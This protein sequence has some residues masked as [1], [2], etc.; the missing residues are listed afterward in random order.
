MSR[1]FAIASAFALVTALASNPAQ[2]AQR[3]FVASNGSDANTATGCGLAQPCRSFTAA[4]TVVDSGG[5]VLAL[6]AAGYGQV[7]IT[8]SA[9]I[10]ANPGFYAGIS[11]SSGSGVTIATAGVN[12]VLRGLNINGIGGSRGVDMIDGTSLSVENCVIS[13]FPAAGRGISITTPA[14]VRVIDS[15][16]RNN[17]NGI[18]V[19]GNAAADIINV[20]ISGHSSSAVFVTG[21]TPGTTRASIS[22]SAAFENNTGFVASGNVNTGTAE[23]WLTRSTASNN[24]FYGIVAQSVT[25]GANAILTISNSMVAGNQQIGLVNNPVAGT[26]TL[27]TLGNNTV[28]RNGT[29]TSGV[30]TTVAPM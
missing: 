5:E 20:K 25:A 24:L 26:S 16:V 30:I 23:L 19:G 1:H 9:T 13:N 14:K 29:D 6:D 17:G 21:D 7:T 15:I 8:K 4:M 18:Y 27:E 28:R 11:V 12:V 22:D 3:V 2:A 10:T